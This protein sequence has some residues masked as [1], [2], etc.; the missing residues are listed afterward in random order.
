MMLPIVWNYCYYLWWM[1]ALA[2]QSAQKSLKTAIFTNLVKHSELET[3]LELVVHPE[4]VVGAN[5]MVCG[6]CWLR[7]HLTLRKNGI[8]ASFFTNLV[9]HL[10]L[11]RYLELGMSPELVFGT[12]A[13]TCGGCRLRRHQNLHKI[14]KNEQI[15]LNKLLTRWRFQKKKTQHVV[16]N[17]KKSLT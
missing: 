15:S 7:Q 5:A 14:P 11:V 10:G 9:T 8:K 17:G 1:P 16:Q 12:N 3:Y 13:M 6:G 4:L 2:S